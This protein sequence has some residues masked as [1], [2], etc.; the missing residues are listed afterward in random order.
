MRATC[1]LTVRRL[2]ASEQELPS[3]LRVQPYPAH[4]LKDAT[5]ADGTTVTIRPI[6]PDDAEIEA[7][8]V[9]NLSDEL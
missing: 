8:F 5:L 7:D 4:L 1:C 2:Q 6:R 9:R 3:R